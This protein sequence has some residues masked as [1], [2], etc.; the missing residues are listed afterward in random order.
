M[1]L[2]THRQPDQSASYVDPNDPSNYF[3][4]GL[5]KP[6]GISFVENEGGSG[7]VYI[8]EVLTEGSA[9]GSSTPLLKG[10][11]L[12]GVDGVSVAGADFD[13]ALD[14]IKGTSGETTKL[15]FF[16][17]PI[18]FLYGPTAPTKE[19]YEGTLLA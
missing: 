10:D 16:R 4:V 8:D 13:G 3:S 7:G 19:W 6:M 9:A 17:G 18:S 15:T 11:Q 12:V 2:T 1:H 14:V 5:A